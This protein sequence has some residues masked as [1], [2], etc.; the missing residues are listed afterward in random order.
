MNHGGIGYITKEGRLELPPDLLE[1]L[2]INLE[3][4]SLYGIY[5]PPPSST[6]YD[7]VR[8]Q[9][10]FMLTPIPPRYWPI[11]GRLLLRLKN[12]P[13]TSKKITEFLKER[14]ISIVMSEMTRSG[15][16]YCAWSLQI[17][18]EELIEREDHSLRN[19][20]IEKTIFY[21][22]D[23]RLL[24]L[25][26]DIEGAFSDSILFF[27][28]NDLDLNTAVYVMPNT[29]LAYFYK[30]YLEHKDDF[31]YSTFKLKG[32]Q[33]SGAELHS[34][35]GK[36]IKIIKEIQRRNNNKDLL[37]PSLVLTDLDTRYLNIRI[38]AIS[39]HDSKRFFELIVDYSR[40]GFPEKCIGIMSAIMDCIPH[41]YNCWGIHNNTL[42]SLPE[43]EE[44]RMMFLLEN[45]RFKGNLHKECI[46]EAKNNF[47]DELKDVLTKCLE[48]CSIDNIQTIPLIYEYAISSVKQRKAYKRGTKFDVF[49]SYSKKDKKIVDMIKDILEKNELE[50]FVFDYDLKS[51]DKFDDEIKQALHDSR[52]IWILWSENS[53][54]SEYVTSEWS[55]GWA[56]DKF[57]VP[58]CYN[59]A[60]NTLPPRLSRL[61][62]AEINSI[63]IFEESSTLSDKLAKFVNEAKARRYDS[64]IFNARR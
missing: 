44:G 48:N 41:Y 53:K 11:C 50:V 28:P 14:N 52:E 16:R 61:Q 24:S 31:I 23:E 15:H 56:N 9:H 7:E 46:F 21:D 5:Y 18:F 33:T 32:K 34:A 12:I 10:D 59:V 22:I 2:N 29:A 1:P 39:Q 17:I 38:L 25:K 13:K 60:F 62:G 26:K 40:N 30:H 4:N 37:L 20:N 58:I 51:A 27:N 63:K 3:N 42:L 45:T 57:M 55:T 8:L 64:L 35:G 49:I 54:G 43:M 47:V 36:F 19:F 6:E